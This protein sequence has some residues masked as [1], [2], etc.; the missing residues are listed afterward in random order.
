MW[1]MFSI[2]TFT[3]KRATSMFCSRNGLHALN[4][5]YEKGTYRAIYD[6]NTGSIYFRTERDIQEQTYLEVREVGHDVMQ[7][8]NS[9]T[10]VRLFHITTIDED[11]DNGLDVYKEDIASLKVEYGAH[12]SDW[13]LG[14]NHSLDIATDILVI[15]NYWRA[16]DII[17]QWD[18]DD[19]EDDYRDVTFTV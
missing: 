5:S 1:Q 16:T 9:D 15:L 11:E 6:E 14:N 18:N 2:R 19:E 12:Y 7:G 3:R 17:D 4:V 10:S 8:W 13:T